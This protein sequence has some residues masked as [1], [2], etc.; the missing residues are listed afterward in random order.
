[1]QPSSPRVRE[2]LQAIQ[3][4]D[5]PHPGGALIEAFIQE[6]ADNELAVGYFQYRCPFILGQGALVPVVADLKDFL[7]DWTALIAACKS[8][9]CLSIS[10]VPCELT[11]SWEVDFGH[12]DEVQDKV[13][14]GDI[15]ARDGGRCRITDEA[16]EPSDPLVVVQILRGL[17]EP[18][19]P[20]GFNTSRSSSDQF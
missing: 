8:L 17:K 10:S 5:L 3:D 14:I 2:V 16:A 19:H 11:R 13:I 18:L 15:T 12:L 7:A 6:S 4:A 1:M 20:V 9:F